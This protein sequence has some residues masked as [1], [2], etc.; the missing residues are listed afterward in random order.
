MESSIESIYKRR[1]ESFTERDVR[2]NTKELLNGL[3][4]AI[5]FREETECDIETQDQDFD[6][7]YYK[8]LEQEKNERTRHNIKHHPN[9]L[10]P[11]W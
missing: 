11:K 7:E 2:L 6:D 8:R 5:S 9:R 1:V 10:N 4:E 3:C